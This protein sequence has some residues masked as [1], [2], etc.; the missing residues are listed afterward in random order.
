MFSHTCAQA[1][2]P[3]AL[4]V[5]MVCQEGN[6]IIENVTYYNDAKLGT[7]LSAEADWGRR[8]LYMGP[9]VCS[10]NLCTISIINFFLF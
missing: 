7:E 5:D 4:S 10:G 3:G 1:N 9:Q 6:F 8:G 2:V